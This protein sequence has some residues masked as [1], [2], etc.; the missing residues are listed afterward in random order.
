M[1]FRCRWLDDA[2][3]R[4]AFKPD[5]PATLTLGLPILLGSADYADAG[6][7]GCAC[8]QGPFDAGEENR[9]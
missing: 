5:T 6:C 3:G 2:C 9:A 7:F 8:G 1:G 4:C